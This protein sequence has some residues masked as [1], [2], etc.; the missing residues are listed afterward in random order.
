MYQTDPEQRR[1]ESNIGT[2][3]LSNARQ[4]AV[5]PVGKQ[6]SLMCCGQEE[7]PVGCINSGKPGHPH[8]HTEWSF[9]TST[10][11]Q[12]TS[13]Q[14]CLPNQKVLLRSSTFRKRIT[15][16]VSFTFRVFLSEVRE[17]FL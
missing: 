4:K 11:S 12:N 6:E 3:S 14:R 16:S 17:P 8:G 15:G 5:C 10:W 7:V 2:E 1:L 13:I 9:P